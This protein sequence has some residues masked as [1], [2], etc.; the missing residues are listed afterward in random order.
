M[1][2]FKNYEHVFATLD[3]IS[4]LL[5]LCNNSHHCK[6]EV[7]STIVVAATSANFF[8]GPEKP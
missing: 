5:Y 7:P 3:N 1:N 2:H 6:L 4:I 8:R